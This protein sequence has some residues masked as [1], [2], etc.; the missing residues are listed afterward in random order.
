MSACRRI[1]SRSPMSAQTPCRQQR[2]LHRSS[3]HRWGNFAWNTCGS[4][5]ILEH[6]SSVRESCPRTADEAPILFACASMGKTDVKFFSANPAHDNRWNRTNGSIRPPE[7]DGIRNGLRWSHPDRD[8]FS[9]K[10]L[11]EPTDMSSGVL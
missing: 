11:S 9:L 1:T 7:D 8:F 6:L 3:A 4:I 2:L 5:F 10:I